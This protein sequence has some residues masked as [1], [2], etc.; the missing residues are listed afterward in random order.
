M[1]G[2]NATRNE[3]K[4]LAVSHFEKKATINKIPILSYFSCQVMMRRFIK[5]SN[6][7]LIRFEYFEENLL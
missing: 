1:K 4:W 5:K 7:P 6:L 3:V 2:I